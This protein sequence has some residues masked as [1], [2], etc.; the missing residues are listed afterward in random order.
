MPLLMCRPTVL[1]IHNGIPLSQLSVMQ[2]I[3]IFIPFA[4][5]IITVYYYGNC[6]SCFKWHDNGPF[7]HLQF[8]VSACV[9]THTLTSNFPFLHKTDSCECTL[10]PLATLMSLKTGSLI[11]RVLKSLK[12]SLSCESVPFNLRPLQKFG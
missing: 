1:F 4:P 3:L 9:T 2:F 12:V 11:S 8:N 7:L 6:Q 5:F 10:L